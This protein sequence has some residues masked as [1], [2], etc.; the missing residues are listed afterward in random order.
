MENQTEKNMEHEMETGAILGL[1]DDTFYRDHMGLCAQT[2]SRI[3]NMKPPQKNPLQH[4][5][6]YWI[7]GRVW[8]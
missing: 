5:G 2:P 4:C 1:K 7:I 8:C 6:D 3:Q